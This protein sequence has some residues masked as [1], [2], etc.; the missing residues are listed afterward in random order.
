MNFPHHGFPGCSVREDYTVQSLEAR[1]YNFKDLTQEWRLAFRE[2]DGRNSADPTR[3]DANPSPVR[4]HANLGLTQQQQQ[5][6]SETLDSTDKYQ[7]LRRWLTLMTI[8]MMTMMMMI[9]GDDEDGD[10]I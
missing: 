1:T 2:E 9:D 8:A 4:M 10:D 7:S 5:Q 3:P 6:E